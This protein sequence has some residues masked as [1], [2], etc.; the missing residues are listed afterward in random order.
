MVRFAYTAHVGRRD[1][2]ACSTRQILHG[3]S[4]VL[5]LCRVRTQNGAAASIR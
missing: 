3:G 2:S 5:P 4:G 1:L